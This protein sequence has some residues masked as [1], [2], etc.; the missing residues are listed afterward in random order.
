[1]PTKRSSNNCTMNIKS[2]AIGRLSTK[3]NVF[4]AP[5]AGFSDFAFRNICY[6]LGAGLCFTEMVSVKGLTY[7]GQGTKELL[8]TTDAEY[9]KA[10]QLFGDDPDIFVKAVKLTELDKF[11]LIDVNMGCPVPKVFN[12][13]EGSALLLKPDVAEAI[14]SKLAK[15]GKTVSVK[16]RLGVERGQ[17]VAVELGKRLEGAG[18]K[19]LTLHAR[20]KCDY[21]SG[22]PDYA[23][24]E[25]LKN[26]VKIPV[27]FNG[28][29][30]TASD[31]DMAMEKSGADGVML[32]RGALRTP[33][34][35]NEILKTPLPDKRELIT[36]HF[37]M[38][39]DDKGERAACTYF[40]K[41]MALY[42]KNVRGAKKLKEKVFVA[43]TK[44]E[45]HDVID[46]AFS[47]NE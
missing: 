32:A 42:L 3:N 43:L 27:I 31:A 44:K 23:E 29:I 41:Q 15:A 19:L 10:V 39:Y 12:N 9:V 20:A 7:G 46:E 6:T 35:I 33:W 13:G 11:D 25:R 37:D 26:A 16:M 47:L 45:Y 2:L 18:A 1:M 17:N 30:F 5:L 8:K 28:G 34:L 4:V 21:Y 36:R 22:E 40:R 24:C 14:V 38:I